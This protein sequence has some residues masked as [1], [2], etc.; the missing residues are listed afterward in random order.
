MKE[1]NESPT[2]AQ[3]LRGMGT[4]S[5]V[6]FTN[7]VGILPTNNFQ[8]GQFEYAK[9]I[10][11]QTIAATV[12]RRNKGCYSCPIGCARVTETLPGSRYQGR[13]EGPE[14]ESIFGLGS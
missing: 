10:D 4:A 14:Y 7:T 3:A 6:G 9:A 12:L 1:I 8:Q 2:A 13:G 11:G 5:T